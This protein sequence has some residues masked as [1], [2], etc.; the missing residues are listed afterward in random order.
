[1][2]AE[3]ADEDHAFGPLKEYKVKKLLPRMLT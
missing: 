1:V 2:E 3:D